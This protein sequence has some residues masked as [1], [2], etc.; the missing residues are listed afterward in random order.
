M[1]RGLVA[2]LLEELGEGD[3]GAVEATVVIVVE[4]VEVRIFA[5]E[6][7]GATGPAEGIRRQ[8]TVE[9]HAFGGDAVDVGGFV[10]AG[11]VGADG[12]VGVVVAEDEDNV[13]RR[14][15]RLCDEYEQCRNNPMPGWVPHSI[16]PS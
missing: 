8:A 1:S 13:R 4:A 9:A 10:Q 5:G 16:T 14:R 6:D 7:A 12:L 3:L 15:V 11:A 2:S